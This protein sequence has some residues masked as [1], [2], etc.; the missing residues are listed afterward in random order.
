MKKLI[1]TVLIFSAGFMLT[2]QAQSK[3]YATYSYSIAAPV[4]NQGVAGGGSFDGKAAS[5]VG[6]RYLIKNG[7]VLSLETGLEYG[8][9]NYER[10]P[11]FYPGLDMTSKS[12]KLNLITVPVYA[13]V[14]FLKYLF[15]NGGA[16]VDFEVNKKNTIQKQSGLGFGLGIGGKLDLG[17]FSMMVN[18]FVQRHALIPFEKLGTRQS[19]MNAGVRIGVGYAF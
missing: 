5:S 12:E 8:F 18:P 19:L 16:L 14:T 2:A 13:N 6:L 9:F 4:Y 1:L 11:A 17:H 10:G 3:I 7:K 15:V